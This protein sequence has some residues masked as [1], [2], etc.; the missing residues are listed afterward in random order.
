MKLS[1]VMGR[2]APVVGLSSL[3]GDPASVRT[4]GASADAVTLGGAQE[5]LAHVEHMQAN[6][7][8][9]YAYWGYQG[10]VSYWRAVVSLLEAADVTG[11]DNLPDI[12]PDFLNRN[13]VVMDACH[14]M[15]K[16]AES[17]KAAAVAS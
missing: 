1:E 12:E 3:I 7:Q 10:Q 14:Y 5:A 16:W 2:L 6:A 8:S 15:E 13:L 11:P 17:V 4:Q 9:D